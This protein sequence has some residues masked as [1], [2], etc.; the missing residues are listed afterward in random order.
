MSISMSELA[1]SYLFHIARTA[2]IEPER[3]KDV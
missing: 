1:H 3:I 2:C